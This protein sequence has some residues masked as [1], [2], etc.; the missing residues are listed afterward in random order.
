MGIEVTDLRQVIKKPD[1]TVEDLVN[2]FFDELSARDIL[3][4]PILYGRTFETLTGIPKEFDIRK[5]LMYLNT[6]SQG[7]S[8]FDYERHRMMFQKM[9]NER[10]SILMSRPGIVCDI[11]KMLV[12]DILR[13]INEHIDETLNRSSLSFVYW[14]QRVTGTPKSDLINEVI[15]VNL[16]NGTK[17]V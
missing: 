6:D 14:I 12:I 10:F 1:Y 11:S 16:E 2:Y 4:N 9:H 8:Y 5:N 3:R 13:L 15:L 7:D 17:H